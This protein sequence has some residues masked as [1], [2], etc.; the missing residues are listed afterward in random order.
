MGL[1]V[2]ANRLQ[3]PGLANGALDALEARRRQEGAIQTKSF[4]YVYNNTEEED[5]LQRYIIDVCI[6]MI[7]SFS[8]EIKTEHFPEELTQDIFVASLTEQIKPE[9]T[10]A[11][12]TKTEEDGG[13]DTARYHLKIER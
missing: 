6:L 11:E 5:G 10:K 1:W 4:S 9:Q 13:I 8:D 12:Q 3:M 7:L 2:L